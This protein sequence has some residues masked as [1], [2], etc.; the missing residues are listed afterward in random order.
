MATAA[1][2]SW[3]LPPQS[4]AKAG[5]QQVDVAWLQFP[6]A[7]EGALE[8]GLAS[9]GPQPQERQPPACVSENECTNGAA[10]AVSIY[11]GL[12]GL[13]AVQEPSCKVTERRC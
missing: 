5:D 3:K 4:G 12:N 10:F 6:A 2:S 8:G 13:P 11:W 9:T 7:L 1:G